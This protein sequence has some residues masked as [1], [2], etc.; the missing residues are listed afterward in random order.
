MAFVLFDWLEGVPANVIANMIALAVGFAGSRLWAKAAYRRMWSLH[1][2]SK[3]VIFVAAD[4]HEEIHKGSARY[5]RP[6]TGVGQVRALA[7]I[8]PS[9]RTAYRRVDLSKI[10]MSDEGMRSELRSDLITLGGAKNNRVTEMIM[11]KLSTLY[12]L[13]P[14]SPGEELSWIDR[15][16]ARPTSYEATGGTHLTS[17]DQV[18]R[19]Y[20]VMVKAPN[21]WNPKSTVIVLFGASTHGTAAA[22]AYFVGQRRWARPDHFAALVEVNVAGG[23]TGEAILRE[24]RPLEKRAPPATPGGQES[25]MPADDRPS[26]DG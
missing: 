26:R 6:A 14:P 22:A 2:P 24:L 15:E 9:L 25:P 4:A 20:G 19:D 23:Y 7:L 8:A 11:N 13:P 18:E 10:L 21:P 16:G 12:E 5:V 1:D 3:L 17:D